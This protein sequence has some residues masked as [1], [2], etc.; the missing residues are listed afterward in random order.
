MTDFFK[1]IYACKAAA[2]ETMV[3]YEDYQGNILQA[4]REILPL[5]GSDVVE[6]GAGTGRLT[7]MLAQMVGSIK[8]F[9]SSAHMLSVATE[10][11]M[12]LGLA[13]WETVVADN[14]QLPVADASADLAVAGWSLAH[15]VGWYPD[16]WRTEIQAALNEMSR[17][18]RSGGTLL[19]FETLGTGFTEPTPPTPGL[20]E[21]YQ[22]LETER[23]FT[24]RWIRTDYQFESAAQA[25]ALTRFFFG[26]ELAQ[27]IL[28]KDWAILPECTGIWFK[29]IG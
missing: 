3:S 1:D 6:L 12:A 23:G 10:K 11:M 25:A 18:L 4:L 17:T 26:D 2:Y 28:E 21:F 7:T 9:D 13:N 5:E 15:S 14:R 19:L 16:T 29:G 24:R 20:A 27:Q 8:A 22:W